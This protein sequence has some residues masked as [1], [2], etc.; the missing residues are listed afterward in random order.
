MGCVVML[1]ARYPE[2][3]DEW[4]L[5]WA[6]LLLQD[7]LDAVTGASAGPRHGPTQPSPALE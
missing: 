3:R 2:R 6:R 1:A 7:K 5:M 4:T